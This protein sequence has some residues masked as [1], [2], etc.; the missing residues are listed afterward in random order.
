[1]QAY[2]TTAGETR[3]LIAVPTFKRPEMVQDL[4]RELVRQCHHLAAVRNSVTARVLVIDNDVHLSAIRAIAAASDL[5]EEPLLTTSSVTEPG[6]V[7]VRNHALGESSSD[8]ALVFID[9][10][11]SPSD[12]WLVTLVDCW[13]KYSAA[14]VSGHVVPIYPDG[15]SKAVREGGF[16][17]RPSWPTGTRRQMAATNN[18]LLDLAAVHRAGDLRFDPRFALLGG[19]DNAFTFALAAADVGPI[20]WCQ[21]AWVHDLIPESRATLRWVLERQFSFG[22]RH[23]WSKRGG[24]TRVERAADAVQVVASGIWRLASGLALLVRGASTGRTGVMAQ[25]AG[26]LARGAGLISSLAGLE[27][28]QYGNSATGSFRSRIRV[29]GRHPSGRG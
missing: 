4:T 24:F 25:G 23:G 14:A 12:E 15:T 19:E 21:E 27:L 22:L 28:A 1:M 8:D 26:S 6:V 2:A 5:R 29:A 13:Q 20:V 10:D 9:D 18:L 11:E 3:I 16:F 7:A 17:V